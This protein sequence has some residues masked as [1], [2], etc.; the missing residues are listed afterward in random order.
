MGTIATLK[1]PVEYEYDTSLE[2]NQM[3][4]ISGEA[5]V[6]RVKT[7][8]TFDTAMDG[9]IGDEIIIQFYLKIY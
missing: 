7:G 8:I 4:A 6:S 1:V 2:T 3:K 9:M 5:I